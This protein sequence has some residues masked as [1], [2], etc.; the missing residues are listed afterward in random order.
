MR[1]DPLHD[2]LVYI[3]SK[4]NRRFESFVPRARCRAVNEMV[5]CLI[6]LCN[7]LCEICELLQEYISSQVL[8]MIPDSVY[9]ISIVVQIFSVV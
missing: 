9:L 1:K 4:V 5:F 2:I 8:I 3:L 7:A 6:I